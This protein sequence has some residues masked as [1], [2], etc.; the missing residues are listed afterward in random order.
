[1]LH[2]RGIP[3]VCRNKERRSASAKRSLS[4]EASRVSGAQQFP[5]TDLIF[6]FIFY[7]EKMNGRNPDEL[8]K[9]LMQTK[10][11]NQITTWVKSQY[12]KQDSRASS[13]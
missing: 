2:Q 1:M 12:N 3:S 13:E 6:W 11:V 8:S 4:H 7:Q 9:S 5:D 10:K